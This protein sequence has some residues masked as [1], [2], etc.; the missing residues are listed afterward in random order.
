M[1][2]LRLRGA[3]K[4]PQKSHGRR[5]GGPAGGS[6]GPPIRDG[7]LEP[8]LDRAAVA[9][10][11]HLQTKFLRRELQRPQPVPLGPASGPVAQRSFLSAGRQGVSTQL[12]LPGPPRFHCFGRVAASRP[13]VD[14]RP[15]RGSHR[16]TPEKLSESSLLWPFLLESPEPAIEIG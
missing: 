15:W 13:P 8:A 10:D 3:G 6:G 11:A 14:D 7:S 5:P 4:D 16:S 12:K 9:R 2:E 1:C